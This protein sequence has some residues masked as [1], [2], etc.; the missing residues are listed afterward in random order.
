[1]NSKRVTFCIETPS[2]LMFE[3]EKPEPVEF[4]I[5]GYA[6]VQTPS[7]YEGPRVITPTGYEQ[8]LQT[9]DTR[10]TSNIKVNPIPTNYGL[11]TWNGS[12]ITVS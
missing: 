4:A 11:I 12:V 1:M 10:L 5:P 6:V 9:K 2:P 8:V 7:E 3:V